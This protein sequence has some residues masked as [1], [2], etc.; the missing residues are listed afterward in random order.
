MSKVN[1]AECDGWMLLVFYITAPHRTDD[2]DLDSNR[3]LTATKVLL[4]K[5][6]NGAI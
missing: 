3:G 6:R 1:G 2:L 4:Y 5:T